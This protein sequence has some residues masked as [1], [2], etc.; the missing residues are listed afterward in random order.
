MYLDIRVSCKISWKHLFLGFFLVICQTGWRILFFLDCF[1]FYLY[2]ASKCDQNTFYL[3][4]SSNLVNTF[5]QLQYDINSICISEGWFCTVL[6][7]CK[8]NFPFRI[9]RLLSSFHQV[10][11]HNGF[12]PITYTFSKNSNHWLQSL[13]EVIRQNMPGVNKLFVFKS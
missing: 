11:H 3:F 2:L 7:H 9:S 6:G 10:D 1:F 4:Q 8:S 5:I 13:L 12:D